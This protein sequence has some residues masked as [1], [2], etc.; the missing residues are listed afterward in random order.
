MA[1]VIDE[2][3]YRL[4]T[5][6]FDSRFPKTNQ[7]CNCFQKRCNKA[8]SA[9]DMDVTPCDW[10]QV[11]KSICHAFLEKSKCIQFLIWTFSGR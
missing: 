1:Y 5:A 11:Y 2:K 10:Y 3:I 6:P 8:L 9:K 7:P 4:Q